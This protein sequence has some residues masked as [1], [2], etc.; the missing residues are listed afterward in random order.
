VRVRLAQRLAMLTFVVSDTGPGVPPAQLPLMFKEFTQLD[1]SRARRFEGAGMGLAIVQGLLKLFG[2]SVSVESAVGEG[3]TFTVTIP[4]GPVEAAEPPGVPAVN[5]P[6]H[7]QSQILIVD[8]N[9]LIRESLREMITRMGYHAAAVGS[10]RDALGWLDF[11]RCDV[12][13]LDLHMPDQDGYA[14]FKEF[15]ARSGP[16][17]GV[18]VIA[19]SAYAPDATSADAGVFFEYLVK[20]VHY[21][22]LRGALQRALSARSTV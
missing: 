4:V 7:A 19:V 10:A 15:S 12:V 5:T 21:E 1:G 8:D 16:S 11:Q 14:F 20:P 6:D 17:A 3:T 9:G 2:G 18:P 13:L 22:D